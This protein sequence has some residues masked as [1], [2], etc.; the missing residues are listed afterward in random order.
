MASAL[1]CLF[2]QSQFPSALMVP[3][4]GSILTREQLTVSLTDVFRDVLLLD[5]GVCIS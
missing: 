3:G 2:E 5:A 1:K 4:S